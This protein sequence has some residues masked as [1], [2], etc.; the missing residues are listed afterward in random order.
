MSVNQR[1]PGHA[2]R[3]AALELRQLR[4]GHGGA[5]LFSGL[6]A[7]FPTGLSLILG[8]D[9]AGKTSLLRLFAGDVLPES[10]Q[11]LFHGV[12]AQERPHDHR[13]QVFWRDPRAP[14]PEGMTPLV[15]MEDCRRAHAAWS[16]R[17]WDRHVAGF[18]LEPHLHK[19]MQQLSTGSQ[20]KVLLAAALASGA[21][22]TLIDE[23]V[24]ALDRSSIGYLTAA[25][26]A[27][28]ELPGEPRRLLIVAHYEPFGD[29]PWRE[30]LAL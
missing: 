1:S 3:A 23:P 16:E 28:A 17:E 14:W 9:G 5:P 2:D 27:E 12:S 6:T 18:G 15:W 19:A 4:F 8:G 20:R 26:R 7:D 22:L 25:L 13:A 21:P 24:A 11:V 30:T 10:G 29:L